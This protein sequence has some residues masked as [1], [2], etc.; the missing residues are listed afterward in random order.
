MR[1][2]LLL[3][4]IYYASGFCCAVNATSCA[5]ITTYTAYSGTFNDGTA[6]TDSIDPDTNCEFLIS[7]VN[8]PITMTM[9]RVDVTPGTDFFM[10]FDGATKGDPI[11]FIFSGNLPAPVTLTST[12]NQVLVNMFSGLTSTGGLGF[13]ITYSAPAS[14]TPAPTVGKPSDPDTL[15]ALH[16][17]L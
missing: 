8:S 17:R 9:N 15:N 16:H 11:L 13:E 2:L 4:S 7:T 6:D 10:V 3:G 12:G 1:L 14:P 5:G